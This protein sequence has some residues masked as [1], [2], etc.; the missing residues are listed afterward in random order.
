MGLPDV[1]LGVLGVG[2]GCGLPEQAGDFQED[3]PLFLQQRARTFF[4]F[5][6]CMYVFGCTGTSLLP[7][8]FSSCGERVPL[9][10]EV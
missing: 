5:F 8:L 3:N 7:G 2:G 4:F 1:M 10:T 9:F 6:Y